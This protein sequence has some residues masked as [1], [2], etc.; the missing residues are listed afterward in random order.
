MR[1]DEQ[2]SDIRCDVLET[3]GHVTTKSS[4]CIEVRFINPGECV[5][6]WE[7]SGSM[8]C[9]VI[10][11]VS[12]QY[13]EFYVHVGW[14]KLGR[15][16]HLGRGAFR[17]TSERQEFDEEEYFVRV[18]V[19]CGEND[20]W[21]VSDMTALGGSEQL[22]NFERLVESELR[23]ISPKAARKIVLPVVDKA[24]GCLAEQGIPYLNEF[25]AHAID[26]AHEE[27]PRIS[28]N[29][30]R[31]TNNPSRSQNAVGDRPRLFRAMLST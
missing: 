29:V 12:P 8:H 24:L 17:P 5:F 2:E 11:S 21:S 23:K 25:L 3:S 28:V 15:F 13:D 30:G 4:I 6:L 10:L 7:P 16:P 22:P 14:S 19:L 27:I 18:S 9:Y 26:K 31:D 20:G 1:G